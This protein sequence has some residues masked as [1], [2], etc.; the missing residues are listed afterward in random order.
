MITREFTHTVAFITCALLTPAGAWPQSAATPVNA[1]SFAPPTAPHG[2]IAQGSMFEVFGSNIAAAGVTIASEFP[3]QTEL[4][5]S[6][7]KIT[8]N[9]TTVDAFMV[10][11]LQN[12]RITAILP[13]NTPVGEGEL[14]VTYNGAA[15]PPVPIRVTAHS[16]G[17]FTLNSGGYGAG[18]FTDA[19][20]FAVNTVA[21]TFRAGDVVD[22]WLTGLG[23]APFSDALQP[24]LEDLSVD[25]HVTVGGRDARVLFKGRAGCC[26]GLDIVRFEAPQG[27]EGCYVPVQVTAGGSPSNVSTVAIAS[28]G[29]PCSDGDLSILTPDLLTKARETGWASLAY[30]TISDS[31]QDRPDGPSNQSESVSAS[32]VRY[33]FDAFFSFT[34]IFGVAE[35]GSCA[36]YPIG[37]LL[38]P[39]IDPERAEFQTLAAGNISISG[40]TGS[41]PL[42]GGGG[43][44]HAFEI[45]TNFFQ[46]GVYTVTGT[47]GRS[48]GAFSADFAVPEK[49]TTNLS[50]L[51]VVDRSRPLVIT[52]DAPSADHVLILGGAADGYYYCLA[53]SEAR[54]LT[55]PSSILSLVPPTPEGLPFSGDIHLWLIKTIP[56]EA[57]GVDRGLMIYTGANVSSP[58]LIFR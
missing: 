27:V 21:D 56:F 10:R 22:A 36:Y 6:S 7:A 58:Y 8:V 17:L 41:L 13:S 35:P 1:A 40:P 51:S 12:G 25:V 42:S 37:A 14:V 19:R 29:G 46:P 52:F 48:V 28:D 15:A 26:A 47:G 43:L 39:Q 11:T 50:T 33:N 23:A 20:S 57:P 32:F 31:S 18:I 44:Y 2:S 54:S 53:E 38:G 49:P 5:G 55:I 34:S 45:D 16:P 9:G 30:V 24:P 3:L 4:A